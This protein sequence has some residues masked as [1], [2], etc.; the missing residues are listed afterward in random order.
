MTS[1]ITRACATIAAG[2]IGIASAAPNSIVEIAWSTGSRFSHQSTIAVGKF[3]EVCGKL[4][5]RDTVRW[6]Y[7]TTASVDFNIH[8]HVGKEVV[9]PI[10]QSQVS[11][12]SDT[13][14][15][16]VAHDYCWMWTNKSAAPVGVVV[17]L[18]R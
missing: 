18:T 5:A 13:L 12:G 3:V 2:F 15:V 4:A 10:K 14:S 9:F 11:S 8:Y 17:E 6:N 1:N 16:A 7:T